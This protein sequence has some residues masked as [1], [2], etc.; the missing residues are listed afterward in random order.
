M[1]ELMTVTSRGGGLGIDQQLALRTAVAWLHREFQGAFDSETIAHVLHTSHDQFAADSAITRFLMAERFTRQRLQALTRIHGH[2]RVD[3]T[4]TALFLDLH[5]ATRSP[6]ALGF[7]HH[8]AD[9]HAIAWSA[10]S[11]PS[12]QINPA[13]IAA[14]HERGIDISREFPKPWTAEIIHAADLVITLGCRDAYPVFPGKRYLHWELD[15]PT[16]LSTDN[17]RPIRNT[18][19]RHVRTLTDQLGVTTRP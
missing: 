16:G 19:E 11:T 15:N 13:A 4:P 8:L 6:M 18:I 12:H 14:M 10:G 5:N 3:D 9:D 2:H 7:F 1:E 17:L